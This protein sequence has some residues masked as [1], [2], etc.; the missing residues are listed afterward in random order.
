MTD[1]VK[2]QIKELKSKGYGYKAISKE[3]NVPLGSVT[4]FLK[5][6]AGK[7][8]ATC[9]CKKCG[10]TLIQTTG[11]RPR[12]FCSDYCR[13]EWWKAHKDERKLKAYYTC[14][15]SCC[16]KSFI[17]YGNK[18]RKYCSWECYANKRKEVANGK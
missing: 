16:N 4:S 17:S 3:L 5:R 13:R 8:K 15:C 14:T 6:E 9:K 11:H 18:N 1:L 2:T 7:E 10:S 12:L